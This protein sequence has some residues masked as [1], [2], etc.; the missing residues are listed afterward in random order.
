MTARPDSTLAN[1]AEQSTGNTT[2]GN[3][4]LDFQ[5]LAVIEPRLKRLE[6]AILG[7]EPPTVMPAYGRHLRVFERQIGLV[8][9]SGLRSRRAFQVAHHH[10]LGLFQD[11]ALAVSLGG[12]E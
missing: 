1:L 10:L 5:R 12:G 4:G 6:E 9:S 3:A 8:I 2:V 11:R 7:Y